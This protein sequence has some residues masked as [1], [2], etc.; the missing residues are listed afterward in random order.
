MGGRDLARAEVPNVT[1][2][3][4][5]YPTVKHE[6]DGRTYSLRTD[7]S[8]D[9][10]PPVTRAD[11]RTFPAGTPAPDLRSRVATTLNKNYRDVIDRN[12]DSLAT[13]SQQKMNFS[14]TRNPNFPSGDYDVVKLGKTLDLRGNPRDTFA[15][16]TTPTNTQQVVRKDNNDIPN[17]LKKNADNIDEDMT[18]V[19]DVVGQ[20]ARS[21]RDFLGKTADNISE[22]IS[23]FFKGVKQGYNG[24]APEQPK[25]PNAGQRGYD[26]SY[27]EPDQSDAETARLGRKD[28]GAVAMPVRSPD[29]TTRDLPG[30]SMDESGRSLN[31]E[32]REGDALLARIKSLALIR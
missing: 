1:R 10:L 19:G 31:Y 29:I 24:K 16:K 13:G 14:G 11:G 22:P 23:N 7:P 6:F 4:D 26:Y 15:T 8:L 21:A 12:M 3:A 5:G 28:T 25:R 20:A 27:D 9:S 30:D 18:D 32:S 2:T 17:F